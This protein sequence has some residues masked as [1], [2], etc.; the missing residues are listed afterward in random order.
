MSA[1]TWSS[2]R[3]PKGREETAPSL[4]NT[5]EIEGSYGKN[6][7]LL[8]YQVNIPGPS[9]LGAK[10][11][12]KGCQLTIPIG[13][14]WHTLEAAGTGMLT[15]STDPKS[16][17]TGKLKTKTLETSGIKSQGFMQLTNPKGWIFQS[18]LFFGDERASMDHRLAHR[19]ALIHKDPPY[20][21]ESRNIP[22]LFSLIKPCKRNCKKE[23]F[24]VLIPELDLNAT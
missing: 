24:S 21:A 20:A 22:A 6:D 1:K 11:F 12:M 23:H 16:Y 9:S 18:F 2:V 10:W 4:S 17:L 5:L 3:Y 13:F 19:A 15:I 7:L 14:N 8:D